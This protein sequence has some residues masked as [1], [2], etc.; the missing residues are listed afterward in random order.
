LDFG[1]ARIK[2][3]HFLFASF[4]HIGYRLIKSHDLDKTVSEGSI[5]HL[6][7]QSGRR[8]EQTFV[9]S[10]L[11]TEKILSISCITPALDSSGRT[12][13]HNRT[14]TI[15]TSDLEEALRPILTSAVPFN[16]PK[17]MDQVTLHM[18]VEM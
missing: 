16:P 9:H 2:L 18:Q 12:T 13:S 3:G 11:P 8:D 15:S 10:F 6:C 1:H 7:R 4:N 5:I 14:V 17:Q